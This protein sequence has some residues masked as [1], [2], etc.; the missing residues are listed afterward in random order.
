MAKH[1][2][3]D[4]HYHTNV[5]RLPRA[6]RIRKL[7]QHMKC[8][9]ETA[10]D[11]V[12]STEHAY[13]KPLDAYLYLRDATKNL[14]THIIPAVEAISSEGVDII[15]LYR[16]EED[17]KNA[18][19][20]IKPFGWAINDMNKLRDETGAI[21]V[22]PHP[23]TPGRTGLANVM[24][25]D[26]FM[27]LQKDADY[28]EIHNGLSLH[29]LENGFKRSKIFNSR[30]LENSVR[31][32]FRLPKKFRLDT[33][34]WAVSSDAHFPSHQRI[35]GSLSAAIDEDDW[36]SFL[37]QKHHF[38]RKSVRNA[39]QTQLLKLWHLLQSSACT[40]G[41]VVEKNTLK[42]K[43]KFRKLSKQVKNNDPK[44]VAE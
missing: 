36:F 10:V 38:K 22:I 37:Q 1:T 23:F 28:V 30:K 8:L 5:Y 4:L 32:T 12:A 39:S 17:L 29:F 21:N 41:E 13:K 26:C 44:Q 43:V 9:Q 11:Y 42:S 31:Y 34:G 24:G 27:D 6:Q 35:V 18:L 20:L 16:N 40:L 15:Y 2:T 33:T 19:K 25:P 7:N 3:F 14:K